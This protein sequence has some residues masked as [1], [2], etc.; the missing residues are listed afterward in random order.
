MSIIADALTE[1]ST[2]NRTVKKDEKVISTTFRIKVILVKS[3]QDL[4][5][6]I[7]S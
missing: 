7:Y 6:A 3:N 2:S 4:K 5:N 1:K